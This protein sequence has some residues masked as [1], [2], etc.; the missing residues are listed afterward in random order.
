MFKK[1]NWL[2]PVFFFPESVDRKHQYTPLRPG[3]P[4]E[5]QSI[6]D[7]IFTSFSKIFHE[8]HRSP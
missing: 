3:F 5:M 8:I 1:V 4:T 6:D 2:I 7:D